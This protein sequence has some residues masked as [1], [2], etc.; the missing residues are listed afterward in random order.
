MIDPASLWIVGRELSNALGIPRTTII[1]AAKVGALETVR[2]ACGRLACTTEA[3]E[4]WS[5]KQLAASPAADPVS[6]SP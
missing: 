6:S 1:S 3:A 4:Q 5:G 2:M